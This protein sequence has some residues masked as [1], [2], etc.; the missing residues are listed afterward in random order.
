MGTVLDCLNELN[1]TELVTQLGRTELEAIL[2][3]SDRDLT[4][5]APSNDAISDLDLAGIELLSDDN[6]NTTFAAHIVGRQVSGK[7]LFHGDIISPLAEDRRLH[8]T[9]VYSGSWRERS[10]VCS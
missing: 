5:F 7:R 3:S 8:V 1:L 9:E 4:I 6:V 10:E 2:S